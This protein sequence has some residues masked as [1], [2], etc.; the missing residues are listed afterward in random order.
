MN[1]EYTKSID[2][3]ICTLYKDTYHNWIMC[4]HIM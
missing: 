4:A 1:K 2:V 3:D